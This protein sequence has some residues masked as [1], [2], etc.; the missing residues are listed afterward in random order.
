MHCDFKSSNVFIGGDTEKMEVKIGDFG[1]SILDAKEVITTKMSSQEPFRGGGTMPFVAPEILKGGKPS[2]LSD[3]YSFGMFSVE[4]LVPSWSNPWD[5]VCRPMLIPS[6]VLANMHPTLPSYLDG[7]LTEVLGSYTGLIKKCW[8]ENPTE[9]PSLL[10]I[11]CELESI[12]NKISSPRIPDPKVSSNSL[13]ED[14][15]FRFPENTDD[16][17]CH[18]LNLSIHQGPSEMAAPAKTTETL[19]TGYLARFG[20]FSLKQFQKHAIQAVELCCDSIIIQPTA[21]GK[22]ICFQ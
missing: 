3:I 18:I 5:G 2:M 6:K 4:L 16:V 8:V 21:S 17:Q 10:A 12:R 11:V 19:W 15:K 13:A 14:V 20:H 7:V 22:S 1:E 9:R